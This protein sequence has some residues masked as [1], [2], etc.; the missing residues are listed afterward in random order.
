MK[1]SSSQTNHFEEASSGRTSSL[2]RPS[3]AI[4]MA[5][6]GSG[7]KRLLRILDQSANT[8]C[9]GEPYNLASSPF[10][11]LRTFPRGWV[12]TTDDERLLEAQWDQAARWTAVR[13]GARD[14]LPPPPKE[15]HYSLARRLGL[16]RAVSSETL[17]KQVSLIMP[18]LSEDEWLLPRWIGARTRI[19][20]SLLVMKFNQSPG[21]GKWILAN[22]KDVKVLH[23]V[24]HPA[25]RLSSWRIR[26]LSKGDSELVRQR[27]AAR[28][29]AI[30]DL[31]QSWAHRFGE[32]DQ[33][34]VEESELLFWVYETETIYGAG[35]GRKQYELTLDEQV[36]EEPMTVAKSLY[37]SLGLDWSLRTEEWV[38]AKA[39]HWRER[40]TPW[41]DLLPAR[42]VESVERI[43]DASEVREWWDHDQVV[44]GIDYDWM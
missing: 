22:R 7:S 33:L 15:H 42:S 21:L 4:V 25:A 43:L 38:R 35:N 31:D 34:S 1:R 32:I 6:G 20:Q 30:R 37:R 41:R 11:Q 18:G 10:R 40:A 3:Y 44:S 9:R 29:R 26:H 5:N 19:N 17:R 23:L 12:V 13:M 24:R 2:R 8:H 36:V 14:C 27:N 28:L 16:L 39:R